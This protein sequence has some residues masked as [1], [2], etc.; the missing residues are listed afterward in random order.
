MASTIL[1]TLVVAVKGDTRGL[2]QDLAK[3]QADLTALQTGGTKVARTLAGAFEQFARTGK[4]NFESLKTVALRALDDIAKRAIN[5]GLSQIF[6]SGEGGSSIFGTVLSAL[7]LPG[8]AT[9]GAVTA[10]QPYVVGERGPELFIPQGAG[11]VANTGTTARA[12]AN[13]TVNVAAS[14][15][16]P[17]IMARSAAQ[18]AATVRRS[19]DQGG[20][21]A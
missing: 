13:I 5:A 17:R 11:S 4:F 6:G 18:I 21:L 7:G 2:T 20:R 1:D 16:D 12:T 9:G 15:A 19:L 10:G 3:S 8:R 14:A